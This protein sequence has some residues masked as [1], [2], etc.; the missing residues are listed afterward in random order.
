M[1]FI[2]V[3]VEGIEKENAK[4]QTERMEEEPVDKNSPFEV[5]KSR[6]VE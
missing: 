2:R 6:R 3:H 5:F 4:E 1:L